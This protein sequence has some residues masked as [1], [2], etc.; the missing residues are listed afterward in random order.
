MRRAIAFAFWALTCASAPA[1]EGDGLEPLE[2]RVSTAFTGGMVLVDRG[3]S[4]GLAEG[5]VV[6]FHPRG[7]GTW[8][9]TVVE[10]GE[11]SSRVEL[12]EQGFVPEP[13]TRGEVLLP[14]D[15]VRPAKEEAAESSEHAPWKNADEG[16]TK[17][18]PLLARVKG[19]RPEEREKSM[20][21]RVYITAD[22]IHGTGEERS[23]TYARAGGELTIDN[24]SGRGDSFHFDGE[25]DYR[26]IDLSDEN[27]EDG[28][29]KDLRLDRFS[30]SRGGTRYENRGWEV[31]RFLQRG[32][33][34]FG[35]L[36]G[37][38][39]NQRLDNGDRWGASLGFLPEPDRD[40]DTAEDFQ[41][42]AHYE[43]VSDLSEQLVLAGGFQKTLHHGDHDRD[44]VV[45][46]VRYNPEEG[47]N[48]YGTA[49]VDLYGSSD[50][51][52][53]NGPEI[54]QAIAALGHRWE[55]GNGVELAYHRSLFPQ[56][57]RDEFVIPDDAEIANGH[58][59]RL[60]FDAWRFVSKAH[61][62]HGSAGVW[63]DE[64]ESGGDLQLGLDAADFLMDA[65]HTDFTLF[66][67]AGEFSSV[68]G[69]RVSFTRTT[70]GGSWDL[71][72]EI[73]QHHEIGFSDDIDDILQHR[74]RGGRDFGLVRGW[75]VSTYVEAVTWDEEI[76]FLL[77]A[78]VQKDF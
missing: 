1:Q 18:K 28:S 22:A 53:P 72:Y 70:D 67:Q 10:V 75:R 9:G 55:T 62:V 14:A 52:K 42:S 59:D 24:V 4:D 48:A 8:R 15:R 30:Y 13:G 17:D 6:V 23:D 26:A 76:A 39:W 46:K 21:G 49:W 60:A 41:G 54:T 50:D 31:G 37:V 38:E 66:G 73:G 77:G 51:L 74:L 5:D 71:F 57:D 2:L 33:P 69:A 34:E 40:M 44:L 45:T 43:W 58:H 63:N 68:L 36:D 47:W 56:M 29:H 61:R 78:Y 65:S 11:R 32:M 27:G 16:W 35:V 64:N 20:R 25:I 7:G 12:H 19:V 3:A